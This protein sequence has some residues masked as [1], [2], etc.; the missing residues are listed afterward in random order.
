MK[1]LV[2]YKYF[3]STDYGETVYELPFGKRY[4]YVENPDIEFIYKKLSFSEVWND[5]V[6]SNSNELSDIK[7][8]FELGRTFFRNK[9]Q[10][11]IRIFGDNGYMSL[12]VTE[13]QFKEMHIVRDCQEWNPTITELSK[14]VPADML[15]EYL[16]DRWIAL[17]INTK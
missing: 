7:G 14:Q 9:P 2:K 11:R 1:K 16:H 12:Y 17:S 6:N 3:I 10:I 5:V 15:C 4:D 13:K 8:N